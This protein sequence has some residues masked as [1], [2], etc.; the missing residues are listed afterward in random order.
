MASLRIASDRER[1]PRQLRMMQH[2]HGSVK[3]V[4]V[5]MKDNALF[6]L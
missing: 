1:S 5:D 6:V 3:T 4:A 2:L